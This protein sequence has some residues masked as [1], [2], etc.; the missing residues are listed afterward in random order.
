MPAFRTIVAWG[1]TLLVFSALATLTA[2]NLAARPALA[3]AKLAERHKNTVSVL[4]AALDELAEHPRDPR[5]ARL[6]ALSLSALIYADKAEPYYA[7]ARSQE[8]LSTADLHV[9]ALGLARSNQREQALAAYR[10]ILESHPNDPLALQR[11]STLE[12]T[13]GELY[14]AYELATRLA[15]TQEGAIAGL[16]LQGTLHHEADHPRE[17]VS[18]YEQVLKRDP[19]LRQLPIAESVFWKEFAEDLLRSGRAGESRGYLSDA[20]VRF[21]D[22]ILYNLLGLSHEAMEEI[23]AAEDAWRLANQLDPTSGQPLKN[24]GRT[25]LQRGSL[26]D[27]ER[28]LRA[29][30]ERDPSSYE[31]NYLMSLTLRRQGR[32]DEAKQYL[33][34][35]QEIRRSDAA[36]AH[37]VGDSKTF[38]DRDPSAS[39][40]TEPSPAP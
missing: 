2:Y 30:L 32:L 15:K 25:A 31:A 37:S 24:L 40:T 26:A 19:Q 16:T 14:K 33:T 22:P 18:F 4:A 27:A 39:R 20:A 11:A 13:E 23:P 29:S 6:A 7:I 34:K 12:W 8:L 17:A 3:K 36:K 1:F 28:L 21:N 10:E 38:P 9:R 35:A 5:A